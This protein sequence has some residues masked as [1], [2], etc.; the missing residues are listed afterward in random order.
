MSLFVTLEY[1]KFGRTTECTVCFVSLPP[2][3]TGYSTHPTETHSTHISETMRIALLNSHRIPISSY[4]R[5]ASISFAH[6]RTALPWSVTLLPS[7]SCMICCEAYLHCIDC[8]VKHS[9]EHE[10]F[11]IIDRHSADKHDRQDLVAGDTRC[12]VCGLWSRVIIRSKFKPCSNA[13][14]I[15]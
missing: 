8:L 3:R 1:A 14:S 4:T 5:A 12:V 2:S 6:S 13:Y 11:D 7:L 10:A 15:P 9:L